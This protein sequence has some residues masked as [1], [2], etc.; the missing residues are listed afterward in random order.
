VSHGNKKFKIDRIGTITPMGLSNNW[1][2]YGRKQKAL[3]SR[4]K[5][6]GSVSLNVVFESLD[7]YAKNPE[8]K[9]GNWVLVPHNWKELSEFELHQFRMAHHQK[10]CATAQV[11][12][13]PELGDLLFRVRNEVIE[14]L[15]I[16]FCPVCRFA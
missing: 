6:P 2:S 16:S 8:K 3:T 1:G 10:I 15:E 7:F 13:N 5:H 4:E 12:Y 14:M 9:A 11:P